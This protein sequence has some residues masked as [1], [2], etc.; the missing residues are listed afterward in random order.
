M[1]EKKNT[2]NVLLLFLS[3]HLIIWTL[4]PTFSNVNLP[5]DTIEHLAWASNLEWGFSKHPPLVAFILS[6]F[7]QYF[8]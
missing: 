1:F 4:V 5:L 2:N 7:F 8:W 3:F 6:F